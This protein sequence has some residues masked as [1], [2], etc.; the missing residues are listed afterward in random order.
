M[1]Y[2]AETDF[3]SLRSS[4]K[5]PRLARVL[6][7]RL[8]FHARLTASFPSLP[9]CLCVIFLLSGCGEKKTDPLIQKANAEWIKGQNTR[10]VELFKAVLEKNPT[11]PSAEEALFR[12]GEIYH[13]SLGKSAQAILYFQELLQLSKEG[14]FSHKA[15]KYI[16]EIVEFTFKDFDQAIIEYQNLI[17]KF[18]NEEEKGDHQYRIASIYFKM[19]NYNQA[20]AEWEVL[21]EDYPNSQ[22]VEESQFKVVELLYT[23]QRCPEA[24]EYQEDFQERFPV[25]KFKDEMEFMMASCLEEEGKLK[26]AFN[27]FKALEG[28]YQY[29]AILKT[30]MDGLQKRM[31]KKKVP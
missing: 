8:R 9:A 31:K 4:P 18:D 20:L 29:P 23:Q 2:K 19:Q 10:A 3:V 1:A 15:Q 24:R 22:W 12:L 6:S 26:E 21:L 28:R 11:G 30:K 13:F 7:P 5:P 27:R 25:S 16:A 14:P 17:N